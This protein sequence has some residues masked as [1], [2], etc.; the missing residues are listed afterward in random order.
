MK[1][2]T[3]DFS[4]NL[5]TYGHS[6]IYPFHMPGHKR[7]PEF[8]PMSNPVFMDITE[9]D[10]WDNLHN[11]K[12]IIKQAQERAAT[13]YGA[14][15]TLFLVNGSSSGILAAILGCVKPGQKLLVARNSHKSVYHGMEMGQVQP[16]YMYP[17]YVNPLGIYGSV[18]PEQVEEALKNN[19]DIGAVMITSPTYD[20]VVS[21][22]KSIAAITAAY[23][24]PLIVDEAH[25][26]HFG[27]S[28]EF[29]E[30][31]VRCGA[32]IVIQSVHKT[33]PSMTQTALLHICG[34]LVS[35]ETIYKYSSYVQTTSPSYVLMAAIDQCMAFMEHQ[36]K[37]YLQ[38]HSERIKN[39]LEKCK[40]LKHIKVLSKEDLSGQGVFD[41]DISK[42][43][44][45]FKPI[46]ACGNKIY[47]ILLKEHDLQL[48]MASRDYALAMTSLC[49]TDEAMDRLFNGLKSIDSMGLENEL[50]VYDLPKRENQSMVPEYSLF[51]A[52]QMKTKTVKFEESQ[53]SVC[54]EYAYLY[55]PGI[56]ILA[57]GER[58]DRQHLEKILNSREN[59]FAV[60][61]LRDETG[62]TL[63]ILDV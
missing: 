45:Y 29:P 27:F 18:E 62:Q 35:K 43:L 47:S 30:T 24:I 17:N 46:C 19:K 39:F 60:E 57:P 42:L 63:Q 51:K 54:G 9:V 52:G 34:S 58:I 59:G 21:D 1:N 2:K 6:H 38:R 56:P 7:N 36:G 44:I 26:A 11:P 61:G 14:D 22:I 32:D 8:F 41:F 53:G 25:G 5:E 16:V 4:K 13:L 10:G 50:K 49:D 48:E 23:K 55:P 12:G 3:V 40:V 31:A 20:G 33:L 28:K 37:I 15:E